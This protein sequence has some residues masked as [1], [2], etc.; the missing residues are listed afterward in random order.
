MKEANSNA[1]NDL[2]TSLANLRQLLL[3]Q[4]ST[5]GEIDP[6]ISECIETI[7]T[8]IEELTQLTQPTEIFDALQATLKTY[9]TDLLSVTQRLDVLSNYSFQEILSSLINAEAILDLLSLFANDPNYARTVFNR[10]FEMLSLPVIKDFL[11]EKYPT[12]LFGHAAYVFRVIIHRIQLTA[13]YITFKKTDLQNQVADLR[14]I[15]E[16]VDKNKQN[17]SNADMSITIDAIVTFLWT[18]VDDTILVPKMIETNLPP[19]AV[20]WI[21][22]TNIS[23]DMQRPCI[24]IIHNLARHEQGVQALNNIN[25]INV[26]K[27]FKQ[28]VL[29]PNKT[30]EDE[31]YVELRLLYCMV[32]SLLTEPKEN[33]EDLKNLRKVLDQL[34]QLLV[35]AGQAENDKC[36]E[37]HVSE[38][39]VVLTKLCVHDEILFYVLNESS[40]KN[41]QA[42]SKVEFFCQL[43]TKFR[44]ALASD[45]DLDQLSLTALFNMIWSISFHDQ[46]IEE[47]K[48][49]SKFLVTLK[50]LANDDGEAWVEQYVPKHMSS[51]SK[52]ANGILWNLDENNPGTEY[53]FKIVLQ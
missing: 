34:L 37:F 20:K 9:I 14:L 42:K 33:R 12:Q 38:P 32:L 24:H 6:N 13:Q 28:R 48:S 26:L 11:E 22:M 3:Q 8:R 46:Y 50:S 7:K 29:D 52:A 39:L 25:C 30:N 44:G 16:Y 15:V 41:M 17:L 45:N 35:D 40:V 51:I 23:M 1:S 49:D 43:L 10:S 19:L 4:S 31:L 27:E 47:L 5:D 36:G 2:P 21:S 53:L 18:L